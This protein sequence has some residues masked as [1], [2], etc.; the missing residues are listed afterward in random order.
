MSMKHPAVVVLSA[1]LNGQRVKIGE[2]TYVL[3]D[4]L[5]LCWVGTTDSGEERYVVVLGADLPYFI[6]LCQDLT[7]A[8]TMIVAGNNVLSGLR[9]SHA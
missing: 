5:D 9:G 8:E 6:R 7:P 4:N 1:L 2:M 3:G